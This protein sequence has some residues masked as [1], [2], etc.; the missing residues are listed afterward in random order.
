MPTFPV[1]GQVCT[2]VAHDVTPVWQVLP[3]G[4]HGSPALQETHDPMLQTRR[5]P[6]EVPF[7]SGVP[8]SMHAG[9]PPVQTNEPA[10]HG[11]VV[12]VHEVPAAQVMQAPAL[13]QTMF[14]PQEEPL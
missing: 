7:W 1:T 2:P 14:V 13:L 5:V 8:R 12:G 3:P 10:W 6:Q 11:A 4:V 9:T